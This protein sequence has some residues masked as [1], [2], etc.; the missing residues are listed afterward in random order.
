MDIEVKVKFNMEVRVDWFFEVCFSFV[1]KKGE[2][3]T[4]KHIRDLSRKRKCLNVSEKE[5]GKYHK[6]KC[7]IR[8]EGLKF[9]SIV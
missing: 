6:N 9:A 7:Q 8:F 5:R 1:I 4:N 3:V 2:K